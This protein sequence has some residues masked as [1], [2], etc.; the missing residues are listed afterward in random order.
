MEP[1]TSLIAKL[2][3]II[4]HYEEAMTRTG[5][6]LDKQAAE[7]QTQ[8]DEVQECFRHLSKNGLLPLKRN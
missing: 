3:S 1:I 8:D 7:A 2:A 6:P 5:S 4:V